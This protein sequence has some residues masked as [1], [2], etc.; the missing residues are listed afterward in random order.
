MRFRHMQLVTD[1]LQR[2][3]YDLIEYLH[4]LLWTVCMQYNRSTKIENYAVHNVI[5]F[6]K[7][8]FLSHVLL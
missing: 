3:S 1:V 8:I 6:D 7:L 4:T 2:H 5:F